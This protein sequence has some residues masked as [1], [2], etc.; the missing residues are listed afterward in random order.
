MTDP[1]ALAIGF[2]AVRYAA[3]QTKDGWK[4]TLVVH[5]NDMSTELASHP[6]GT[7]YQVALVEVDD[8]G[9]PVN[10]KRTNAE[11]A[12][13]AAGMLCRNS[14]FQSWCFKEGLTDEIS[15][16][17]AR[18]AIL[19]RCAIRSR[20]ELAVDEGALRLFDQMRLA[21]SQAIK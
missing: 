6:I 14:Q 19:K 7:R 15:E 11:R 21:F 18:E 10:E 3:H 16:A 8:Q 1:K 17:G 4:I 13:S 12:V 5:P 2:E 9:Q 20:A